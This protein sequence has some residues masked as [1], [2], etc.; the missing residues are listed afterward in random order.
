[1]TFLTINVLVVSM[2][3]E[4]HFEGHWKGVALKIGAF[5]ALKIGTFFGP[6]NRDF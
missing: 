5:W 4:L 2:A 3:R 6:V 1:M